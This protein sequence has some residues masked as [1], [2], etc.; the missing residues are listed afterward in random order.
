MWHQT[1]HAGSLHPIIPT[2]PDL[3]FDAFLIA[4]HSFHFEVDSDGA[5]ERRGEGIICIAEQEAGLSYT[6]VT[7]DK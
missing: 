1:L 4:V 2:Y 7:N 5:D 6:A 3:E